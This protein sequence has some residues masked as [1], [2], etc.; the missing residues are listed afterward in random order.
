MYVIDASNWCGEGGVTRNNN[1]SFLPR[2][3]V[4]SLVTGDVDY[5]MEFLYSSDSG[6]KS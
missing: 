5:F 2:T 6:N 3:Q 1:L 4:T